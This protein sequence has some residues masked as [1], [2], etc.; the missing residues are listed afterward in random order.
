[1]TAASFLAMGQVTGPFHPMAEAEAFH[2]PSDAVATQLRRRIPLETR[3]EHG[4]FFTSGELAQRVWEPLL[5]TLSQTSI[6]LDPACGAGSLLFPAIRHLQRTF[7][8]QKAV[9]QIRAADLQKVFV[10]ATRSRVSAELRAAVPID[11]FKVED[12]LTRSTLALHKVTH[13]VMN[14][15]FITTDRPP[16]SQ[17]ANRRTNAAAVFVI[18]ALRNMHSGAHLAAILPEVLRAGSSYAG[19]R[20][21]VLSLS[22]SLEIEPVGLFDTNTN[23]DVFILRA[24]AGQE[25]SGREPGNF[26]MTLKSIHGKVGDNFKIS[27]GAVVPHRTPDDAAMAPFLSAR[28]L[29]A[30]DTLETVRTETPLRAR[31]DTGPFVVIRRTSSP[32]EQERVRAS[33]VCDTR[34]IGVENHLIVAKPLTEGRAACEALL[35]NL[36]DPRTSE[37]MN[38]RIRCRH[39]TVASVADIPWW[40]RPQ[41]GQARG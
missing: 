24:I 32:R 26:G 14:P 17:W 30:W 28:G 33:I 13:V 2:G 19:W 39:L 29:P 8:A 25:P 22:K 12:F 10:D 3:R 15:P 23:V 6:V 31:L 37:Y 21:E 35:T 40:D 41:G 34:P 20:S 36:R 27:V 38:E 1:M 9:Q 18:Q 16:E 5:S 11:S 4:T 7:G